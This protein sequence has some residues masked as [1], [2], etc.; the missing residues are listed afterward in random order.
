MIRTA[1]A[2]RRIPVARLNHLNAHCSSAFEDGIEIF[3]FEPQQHTVPIRS[4]LA[5]ADEAVMMLDCETM[6]LHHKLPI[7]YKPLV[8]TAAMVAL[9]TQQTLIP[10]AACFH[11]VDGDEWLRAHRPSV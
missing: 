9:H 3:Y 2:L 5:V 10:S 6:Q 11:V 8:L 7:G 1:I 4:V